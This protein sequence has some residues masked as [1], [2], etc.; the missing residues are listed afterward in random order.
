MKD[1]CKSAQLVSNLPDSITLNGR[2]EMRK[3]NWPNLWIDSNGYLK[4]ED[5]LWANKGSIGDRSI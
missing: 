5:K 3:L 1:R 2:I 4:S